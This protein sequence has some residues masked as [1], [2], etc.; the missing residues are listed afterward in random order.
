ME[1]AFQK[2][3]RTFLTDYCRVDK[4]RTLGEEGGFGLGLSMAKEIVLHHDGD[5]SIKSSLQA[6][7]LQ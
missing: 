1:L 4:A 5:V 2:K 6:L 3:L 7:H